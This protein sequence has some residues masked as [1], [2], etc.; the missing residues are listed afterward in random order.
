MR[1]AVARVKSSSWRRKRKNAARRR[2]PVF[3][4][5]R[6][7]EGRSSRPVLASSSS[8]WLGR[9]RRLGPFP[10][11][12]QPGT[13]A[14]DD[15]GGGGG[16]DGDGDAGR[17]R[18]NATITPVIP[19]LTWRPAR[20]VGRPDRTTLHRHTLTDLST[21]IVFLFPGR[22]GGVAPLFCAARSNGATNEKRETSPKPHCHG[23]RCDLVTKPEGTERRSSPWLAFAS[24]RM[25]HTHTR[26][27]GYDYSGDRPK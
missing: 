12:H 7:G 8:C 21:R 11:G 14:L 19:P 23:Q 1:R 5:R 16:D 13:R 10:A 17:C 6:I 24:A 18:T 4:S 3:A 2:R 25:A 27:Y 9:S 20:Y 26:H 15:D 22:G